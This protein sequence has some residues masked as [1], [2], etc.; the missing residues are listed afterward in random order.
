MANWGS[1][2]TV[3]TGKTYYYKDYP[4]NKIRLV[5]LNCM[6]LG[7]EMQ[8]QTTWFENVLS[9]TPSDYSVVGATHYPP[10]QRVKLDTTFTSLINNGGS[11]K[12][13]A[14][15]AAVD[16]FINN[17]GK[18]VCWLAGHTHF[19]L[20]EYDSRY[21][22]QLWIVVINAKYENVWGDTQRTEGTK[23]EDG[24]NVVSVDTAKK[25]VK[26]IRVGADR[27]CYL[28]SKQT[29]TLDYS[30]SPATVIYND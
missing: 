28:R 1:G 29:L 24:F 18:F 2:L 17:G 15:M 8:E 19:D 9:S 10:A 20:V 30:T 4:D 11:A 22:N 7:E 5:V 21:P 26:V 13:D 27:D 25:Y 14:F 23:S 16:T 3:Q 12:V 6:L